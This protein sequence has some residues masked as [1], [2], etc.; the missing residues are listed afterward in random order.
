MRRNIRTMDDVL[1]LLD[2]MFE[3]AADRWT[4]RGAGWWDG[5]YA[6]RDRAVPFFRP[7]P[8]E[9]LVAWH[10]SG[11]L[12]LTAGGRVL[13]LGCGPGRNAVWLAQ[14]GYAVDAVDLSPAAL[15]WGRERAA[16]AGV[17]VTFIHADIFDWEPPAPYDLV[18][19]S[20]CFH[21][22]PPHRRISFRAL[23]ERTLAPGGAFGLACFA[24]GAMG[25][26]TSDDDLYREGRLGGGLAYGAAD[27]RGIFEWLSEVE[28]RRMRD[29]PP[30]SEL[31]GEP[32][33]WAGLFRRE[34]STAE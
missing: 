8:D 15:D 13:D 9:S 28:L 26:E 34:Q 4:D 16:D 6:D 23:L 2:A 20:G 32:F 14:Q 10:A 17:D 1:R 25:S 18:Y 31:F 7:A 5:F 33:L 12:E 11:V 30:D 27:L 29:M 24:A 21:H 3:P 22:L 19:D